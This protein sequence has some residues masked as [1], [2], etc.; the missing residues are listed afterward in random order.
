MTAAVVTA[1]RS[2]S[3]YIAN[4]SL[5]ALLLWVA[6]LIIWL[7]SRDYVWGYASFNFLAFLFFYQRWSAP[8]A[9]HRQFHFLMMC[10]LMTNPAFYAYQQLVA[11]FA[12]DSFGM[13]MF[14]YKLADNFIYE[15]ELLLII[16]YALLRRR[17]KANTVKWR[18]DVDGWFSKAGEI[19]RG[20][21]K[22]VRS[23]KKPPDDR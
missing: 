23:R 7:F 9:Q 20:V 1:H 14:W 8:N 6:S 18:H 4:A 16:A 21:K 15:I 12:P 13:S 5:V 3:V 22:A 10:C 17:A 2:G 19:K 11:A